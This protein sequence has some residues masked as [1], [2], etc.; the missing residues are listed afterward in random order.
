M[1]ARIAQSSRWLPDTRIGMSGTSTS[2]RSSTQRGSERNGIAIVV[3][4]DGVA[5]GVAMPMV[6]SRQ[7]I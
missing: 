7:E 5:T 3:C 4:H 2:Q 6:G 1:T